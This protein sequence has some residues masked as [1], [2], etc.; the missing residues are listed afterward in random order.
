MKQL[1]IEE[2]KKVQLS[3]LKNVDAFCK[4][5]NIRYSLNY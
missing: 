5:N 4:E 1:N 3:I 2:I